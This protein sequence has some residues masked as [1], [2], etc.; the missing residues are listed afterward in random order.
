MSVKNIQ[1]GT[2][3]ADVQKSTC[4][5]YA[6]INI[7]TDEVIYIG[8]DNDIATRLRHR[9]HLSKARIND[10]QINRELQTNPQKYRYEVIAISSD[11]EWMQDM[12][13]ALIFSFTAI[14]MCSYNQQQ[15]IDTAKVK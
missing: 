3:Y 15:E 6:Y 8:L 13:A 11:K 4:G 14:G 10:Q 12:E 7:E 1:D 2:Q 5:L 9:N